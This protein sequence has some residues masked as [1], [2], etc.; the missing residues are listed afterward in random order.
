[1]YSVRAQRFDRLYELA[2]SQQ[3]FFS[4]SQARELGYSRQLQAYHV[5]AGDWLKRG[6]GILRLKHF[7]PA[8][9][10]DGFYM[11]YLWAL[12]REGEPEGVFGFGSALYIHELSTYVPP[13]FDLVVPKHFRR[14]SKPPATIFLHKKM[15]DAQDVQRIAG[16]PVTRPLK[17]IIDLL[18]TKVI[19]HDYVLDALKSAIDRLMITKR[20]LRQAQL[21]SAQRARLKDALARINYKSIDE[22]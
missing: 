7:P 8:N 16:L 20:Q 4:A 17:T 22:I 2:E 13:G 1:M 15:L 18:D 11:T 14:H 19:D 9:K 5:G 3:G 10:P 21:T 6:R 12:N